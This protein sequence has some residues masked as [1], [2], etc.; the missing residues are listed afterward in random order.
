M[1]ILN[2]LLIAGCVTFFTALL[3]IHIFT[4]MIA[5]MH[6]Y[7]TCSNS[8]WPHI[9][10]SHSFCNLVNH[11]QVGHSDAWL[12]ERRCL[13]LVSRLTWFQVSVAIF[14]SI[15]SHLLGS[16]PLHLILVIRTGYL[17]VLGKQL[18]FS[19]AKSRTVA[20]SARLNYFYGYFSW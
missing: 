20:T 16:W 5:C 18:G 6:K 17:S 3:G 10:C 7:P 1:L 15:T 8:H 13:A 19:S 11:T 14:F 4:K 9:L 2:L 12:T